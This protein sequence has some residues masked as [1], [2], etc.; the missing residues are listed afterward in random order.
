M[1]FSSVLVLVIH[2]IWVNP[3]LWSNVRPKYC[4]NIHVGG[5]QRFENN[6]TALVCWTSRVGGYKCRESLIAFFIV[7]SWMSELKLQGNKPIIY[8]LFFLNLSG[9]NHANHV[10]MWLWLWLIM[11]TQWLILQAFFQSKPR[12]SGRLFIQTLHIKYLYTF[13]FLSAFPPLPCTTLFIRNAP[14]DSSGGRQGHPQVK[15]FT[16]RENISTLDM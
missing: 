7:I 5:W 15:F 12:K 14:K 10:W 16:L 3:L 4:Y 2:Q 9:W 1:A 8:S 6:G 13:P 11:L